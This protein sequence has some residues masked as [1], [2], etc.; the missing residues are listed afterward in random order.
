MYNPS[1]LQGSPMFERFKIGH[2]VASAAENINSRINKRLG[3]PNRDY[4][5]V[6]HSSSD[7]EAARNTVTATCDHYQKDHS[8]SSSIHKSWQKISQAQVATPS[9]TTKEP[10]L[11]RTI[12]DVRGREQVI[13]TCSFDDACGSSSAQEERPRSI[14]KRKGLDVNGVVDLD[15]SLRVARS[16]KEYLENDNNEV[17]GDL[18]L[19]LSPSSCSL[20]SKLSRLKEDTG[21]G[22]GELKKQNASTLDL[23]L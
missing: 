17:D 21:D 15:L 5:H 14:L 3:V 2:I 9:S 12:E 6:G 4:V 16:K 22:G 18:S 1:P 7:G 8:K 20:F 11:L 13:R 10:D 19:S 23:T